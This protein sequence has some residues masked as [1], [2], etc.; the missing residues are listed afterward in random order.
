MF[1][2]IVGKNIHVHIQ[3]NIYSLMLPDVLRSKIGLRLKFHI[4]E[5]KVQQMIE[6]LP[7]FGVQFGLSTN[8][9]GKI[10]F[11]VFKIGFSGVQV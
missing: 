1:P 3:Y 5:K 6:S 10:G 7:G 11:C 2:A 4:C 8:K 9:Y